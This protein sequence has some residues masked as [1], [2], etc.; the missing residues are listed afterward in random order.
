MVKDYYIADEKQ[1][2]AE[3]FDVDA[4]NVVWHGNYVKF[5][6]VARCSLLEKI[7]YGYKEMVKD[8]YAYPVTSINL[9][10]VKSVYFADTVNVKTFLVE[11]EN[12][13]KIKYEIYNEKGEICTKAES[14]QMALRL[15]TNE[16]CFE[17]SATFIQ[18]VEKILK[19]E[20]KL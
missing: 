4:M 12:C 3:F 2:R 10:Y 1:I 6:E 7:G 5:M 20:G 8:G 9:K 14:T 11:Y 16:S 17:S 13:I 15:D 18:R 19:E